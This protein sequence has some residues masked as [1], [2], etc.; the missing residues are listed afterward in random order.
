MSAWVER[1]VTSPASTRYRA[2]GATISVPDRASARKGLQPVVDL[3]ANGRD[4]VDVKVGKPVLFSPMPRPRL[5]SGRSSPRPGT[6]AGTG[7]YAPARIGTPQDRAFV[8]AV[9]RFT[10]PGTYL[11]AV[12]VASSRTGSRSDIAQVENL[13]RV[14]VVVHR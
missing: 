6:F 7:T 14:R 9:H 13:N 1:G 12:R 3:S 11:V 4:R 2:D 5:E 8:V 10:I